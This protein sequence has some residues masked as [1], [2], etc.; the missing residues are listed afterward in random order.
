MKRA[1]SR[2]SVL[3]VAPEL[4]LEP[5]TGAHT[6]PLS[7]VR[8]LLRQ[9]DVT[10]VGSAPPAADLSALQSTGAAIRSLAAAPYERSIAGRA[11]ARA[12]QAVSP[13]PFL[14]RSYFE[15]MGRAVQKAVEDTRPDALHLVSMYSCWYRDD[16]L[17]AVI[18]LLDVVSALCDA[19]AIS[20]PWRYGAARLQRRTSAGVESR[21]LTKMA[22]VIAINDEDA[23]RLR[24]LQ[25]ESTVVPL[26][27]TVPTDA[28]IEA[29]GGGARAAG[30]LMRPVRAAGGDH[31]LSLLFVGDFQH[32]PNRAAAA[33]IRRELVPEL[34]RRDLRFRLTVAG[35]G[36]ARVHDGSRDGS[37][38]YLGDVPDMAPL[39]RDADIV[40]VPVPF[41]GG[42]K[43]KTLEA[44]AWGK[45]VV[46]TP[47]AF[48]GL[49]VSQGVAFLSVPL[50]GATMAAAVERLARPHV[51]A[52]MGAAGRAYVR[53]HHTQEIV[54]ECVAAVY[55]RVLGAGS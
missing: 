48:T 26:A 47:Q 9:Y 5:L 49:S 22:A 42:T 51:R 23:R 46:G 31:P 36:A 16:R 2:R 1:E 17:P 11:L 18:D 39:Y 21:E 40:L 33:F 41:G 19:A 25:I 55:A 4:P 20:R 54:D 28:E 35:R 53:R 30:P 12:R 29:D 50:D 52:S 27:M 14:S 38:E 45:P 37:V 43:N 24:A 8:A 10:V 6:R 3:V 13:V 34:K 44:M 7:I 32:H 15:G